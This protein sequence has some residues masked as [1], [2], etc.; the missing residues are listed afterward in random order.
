M[1]ELFCTEC[2]GKIS[3]DEFPATSCPR[4]GKEDPMIGVNG[5]IAPGEKGTPCDACSAE[6]TFPDA[7]ASVIRNIG[8]VVYCKSCRSRAGA[9]S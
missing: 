2:R 6:T 7:V 1:I 8:G 9:T 3:L 4:C 5:S